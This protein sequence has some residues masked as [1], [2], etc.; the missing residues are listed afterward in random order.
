MQPH[1]FFY[2]ENSSAS[3]FGGS[4]YLSDFFAGVSI[5]L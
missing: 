3:F 2:A 1:M 5:F 4:S